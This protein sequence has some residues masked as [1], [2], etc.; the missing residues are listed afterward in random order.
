MKILKCNPVYDDRNPT[1]GTPTKLA[2]QT[3]L[4]N[5]IPTTGG[6]PPPFSGAGFPQTSNLLHHK[7]HLL[8]HPLI[9][10]I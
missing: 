6:T 1:E 8:Q 5:L 9:A 4:V 7:P 10:N 2:P 3:P